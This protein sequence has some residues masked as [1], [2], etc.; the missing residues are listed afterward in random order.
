MYRRPPSA[1]LTRTAVEVPVQPARIVAAKPVGMTPCTGWETQEGY[2]QTVRDVKR[3]LEGKDD[4]LARRLTDEMENWSS[5]YGYS[6]VLPAPE[7]ADT[8]ARARVTGRLDYDE[9]STNGDA[10]RPAIV[11]SEHRTASASVGGA[12]SDARA[13]TFEIT[14]GISPGRQ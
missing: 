2:G 13:G 12:G 7:R 8:R 4:D 5:Y 11:G 14:N 10:R 9:T 1:K 3:F 6:G